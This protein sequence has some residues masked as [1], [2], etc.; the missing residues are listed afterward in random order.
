VGNP[1][2]LLTDTAN[3]LYVAMPGLNTVGLYDATTGA[4]INAAF[5]TGIPQAL[6]LALDGLG[7]LFV[8]GYGNGT[9]GEY[10]ALTG[11]TINANFITGLNI[12]YGL[13]LT[14]VPEP[15]TCALFGL[16]ALAL[17]LLRLRR[18]QA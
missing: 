9:V 8:A 17:G 7:H 5:I 10:D 6:G 1:Y 13:A 11:A 14:A 4:A 2:W 15:A 16:G 3:H 18:R 12:P